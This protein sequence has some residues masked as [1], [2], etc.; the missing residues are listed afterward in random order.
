[1]SVPVRRFTRGLFIVPMFLL[2]EAGPGRE[3]GL[4]SASGF[5]AFFMKG[6]FDLPIM[7]TDFAFFI[8]RFTARSYRFCFDRPG[9][10]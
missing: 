3:C 6:S 5:F 7:E 10:P 4:S 1:M 8:L 2:V 9:R